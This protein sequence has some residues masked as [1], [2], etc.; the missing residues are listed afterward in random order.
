MKQSQWDGA[1]QHVTLLFLF[2]CAVTV[3]II[4]WNTWYHK[5]NLPG[6]WTEEELLQ[7]RCF[8]HHVLILRGQSYRIR[9]FAAYR[10]MGYC[11]HAT[12]IYGSVCVETLGECLWNPTCGFEGSPSQQPLTLACCW[13]WPKLVVWSTPPA[14]PQLPECGLG[15]TQWSFLNPMLETPPCAETPLAHLGMFHPQ[16]HD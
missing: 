5:L 16:Q 7:H 14:G 2:L 15:L 1:T 11:C 10:E 6:R 8:E 13:L 12:S 3:S 4:Y 9:W